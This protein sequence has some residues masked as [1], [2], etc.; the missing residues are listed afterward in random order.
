MRVGRW[1][2]WDGWRR[3]RRRSEKVQV[4]DGTLKGG[5]KY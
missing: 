2:S 5:T 4:T 1:K 3:R